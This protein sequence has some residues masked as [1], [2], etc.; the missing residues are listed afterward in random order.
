MKVVNYKIAERGSQFWVY[1]VVDGALLEW[2]EPFAS[3]QDANHW[4]LMSDSPQGSYI[5]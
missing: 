2:H 1:K 5:I 4:I 3:L